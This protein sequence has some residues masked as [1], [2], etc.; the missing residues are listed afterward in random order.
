MCP[1]LK[2]AKNAKSLPPNIQ[3]NNLLYL[4]C[5]FSVGPGRGVSEP[6]PEPCKSRLTGQPA[7]RHQLPTTL[8]QATQGKDF[9]YLTTGRSEASATH[10]SHPSYSKQGFLISNYWPLRGISYPPLSPKLLKAST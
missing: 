1:F 10:H 3:H 4:R 2:I 7:Q 8:T 6:A 9:L 5:P